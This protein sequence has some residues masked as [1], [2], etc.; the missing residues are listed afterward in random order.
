[1]IRKVISWTFYPRLDTNSRKKLMQIVYLNL[2]KEEFWGF[3]C[4]MISKE[5]V[6]G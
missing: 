4:C 2:K 3:C 6:P 5:S 1:M